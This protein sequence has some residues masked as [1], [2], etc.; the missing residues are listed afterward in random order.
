MLD[1]DH[2][3]GVNHNLGHSGADEVL[4]QVAL[5]LS[6]AVRLYDNVGHYGGE[7]FM[8]LA[9]NCNIAQASIV[10]ERARNA[11]SASAVRVSNGPV[12]VSA[13]FGVSAT[14]GDEQ[15][16]AK[17]LIAAAERALAHAKELG[18]N[19]VEGFLPEPGQ[20]IELR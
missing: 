10:A 15:L 20:Q 9:T 1:I 17:A 5:R 14:M 8:I 16:D 12:S 7:E 13:S 18:R 3:K 2:F 19:R 11:L 4:Q 6:A